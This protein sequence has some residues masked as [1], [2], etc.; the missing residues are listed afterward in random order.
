MDA[1]CLVRRHLHPPLQ[2]P[3]LQR[4]TLGRRCRHRSV[5]IAVAFCST[6]PDHHRERPWESYDRDIQPH[7][8]SDLARSLQLLADMQAAGMRPSAAA[9]AR[10]IR[11]LA[12]AGRALEA[13]ALLLEMR[14]LRLRRTP[15]TTTRSSRASSRGRTSA[16]PTASSSRWP[17]T[18]SRGT[19]A[20]TCSCWMPTPAPAASRTRGGSSAR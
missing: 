2:L 18:G 9:Y 16:S 8:G 5:T 4:L 10:L 17:T 20:P 14:H 19:G 15:R 7:A 11:A 3:P 13:E 6:A 1:C 12:R